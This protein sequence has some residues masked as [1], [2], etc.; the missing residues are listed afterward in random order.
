M[1]LPSFTGSRVNT[2]VAVLSGY[3]IVEDA[4]VYNRTPVLLANVTAEVEA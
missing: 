2:T 1:V 4:A 3:T